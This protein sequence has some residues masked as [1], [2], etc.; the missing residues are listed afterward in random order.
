MTTDETERQR[1]EENVLRHIN[2]LGPGTLKPPYH[3]RNLILQNP[4]KAF[5]EYPKYVEN[6]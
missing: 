1:L 5:C 6:A 3:K 4:G 2:S